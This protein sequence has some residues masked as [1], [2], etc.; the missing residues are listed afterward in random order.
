MNGKITLEEVQELIATLEKLML[1]KG[2]PRLSRYDFHAMM[3][4]YHM[5]DYKSS[6]EHYNAR[7]HLG[8]LKSSIDKCSQ[9]VIEHLKPF[10]DKHIPSNNLHS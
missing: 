4:L 9:E 6:N 8:Q 2:H 10:L 1:Y 7:T 3:Q 5:R